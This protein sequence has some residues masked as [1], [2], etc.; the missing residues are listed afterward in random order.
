MKS[1][2][3]IFILLCNWQLYFV[4]CSDTHSDRSLSI[5]TSKE[6]SNRPASPELKN[7]NTTNW[8]TQ[9]DANLTTKDTKTTSSLKHILP[10]GR[11]EDPDREC[12]KLNTCIHNAKKYI[13]NCYCDGICSSYDDC[14]FDAPLATETDKPFA[15]INEKINRSKCY[16]FSTGN[17][18]TGIRVV[19]TCMT[20]SPVQ[21]NRCERATIS[22]MTDLIFVTGD[23]GITYKNEH[24]ALCNGIDNFKRWTLGVK[25]YTNCPLSQLLREGNWSEY[26]HELGQNMAYHLYEAGCSIWQFPVD[27]HQPRYCLR[28]GFIYTTNDHSGWQFASVTC[29]EKTKPIQN[30]DIEAFGSISCC[31]KNSPFPD[32]CLTEFKC[33]ESNEKQTFNSTSKEIGTNS[34]MVFFNF[35]SSN[36]SIMFSNCLHNK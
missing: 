35:K 5:D 34:M 15:D 18:F 16:P 14:C 4:S 26:K 6:V 27:G 21:N 8:R 30:S 24:C 17:V 1:I 10:R 33:Y 13:P 7:I 36:V 25:R 9:H 32:D 20:Y 19:D 23:D 12:S 3:M 29:N 28:S 22:T 11:R 31:I 2:R